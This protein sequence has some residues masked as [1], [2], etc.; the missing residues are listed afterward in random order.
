M[1][2]K[3][4]AFCF[5]MA[6]A[7]AANAQ[8]SIT[9][10]Q[11]LIQP[12]FLEVKTKSDSSFGIGF[13]GPNQTWDFRGVGNWSSTSQVQITRADS[14]PYGSL[15]PAASRSFVYGQTAGTRWY[16]YEQIANN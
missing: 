8:F 16:D 11:V 7:L 13:G 5:V 10:Q 6:S 14:T 3:S 1:L 15:F 9:P 12:R 4:L 2:Q